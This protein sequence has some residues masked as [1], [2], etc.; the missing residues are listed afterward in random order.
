MNYSHILPQTQKRKAFAEDS[1]I[2]KKQKSIFTAHTYQQLPQNGTHRQGTIQRPFPPQIVQQMA[3]RSAPNL[4]LS[5]IYVS[6]PTNAQVAAYR[7]AV[8]TNEWH[9]EWKK[10]PERFGPARPMSLLSQPAIIN[11]STHSLRAKDIHLNHWDCAHEPDGAIAQRRIQEQERTKK[12]TK[13]ELMQ[14]I[15]Q[16][17]MRGLVKQAAQ[18]AHVIDLTEDDVVS[19]TQLLMI[20]GAENTENHPPNWDDRLLNSLQG[21][22]GYGDFLFGLPFDLAVQE[23]SCYL[24]WNPQNTYGSQ[25]N[26]G[27][28]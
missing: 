27:V 23:P 3:T 18:N 13:I 5:Q 15:K 8:I 2:A 16:E 7:D 21:M 12:R 28:Y 14:A 4:Q 22:T 20:Q 10:E 17:Q 1:R 24:P 9:E 19:N 11:L 25:H 26:Y 6:A